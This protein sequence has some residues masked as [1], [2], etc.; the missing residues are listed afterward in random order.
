MTQPGGSQ[1]LRVATLCGSI[2]PL[3]SGTDDYD[4]ILTA[5]L[6]ERGVA[7]C[8]VNPGD[9]GL[10]AVRRLLQAVQLARPD[11]ILMQ[12]PTDAFGRSFAPHVFALLQ[13]I[14]PLVVTLHE[15]TASHVLRR[16]SIGP[17]LARAAGVVVTAEREMDGLRAWYPWLRRRLRL[18]PIGANV[19]ARTWRPTPTPNV[20]C[21]GQIRPGKGI[22][23]FIA[24]RQRLAVLAPQAE[25]T[26]IGSP[27]PQFAAYFT[28]IAEAAKAHDI[29]LITGL[30]RSGVSDRLSAASLALLPYP[31]G[32][33]F[34]RGSL[35]AAAVCGVPI[36][37]T[38][39]PDTPPALAAL[40]S[41]A[42]T[43]E[44]MTAL[45][46]GYLGDPALLERAHQNSRQIGHMTGWPAIADRYI[47]IFRSLPQRNVRPAM[48][49]G[50]A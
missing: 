19:P 48:A 29:G 24:C 15:F 32:A 25:F 10:P 30:D 3:F 44:D 39:G 38:T 22:E 1:A 5:A 34:R 40:L 20:V 31:G 18:I 4:E 11:A 9:W 49:V 26:L 47:D 21:F 45:A 42:T 13:R 37:S 46:A 6:R 16:A 41:P 2:K 35:L 23:E 12:Y 33:S 43:V 14:A 27:V 50:A 7:V 17:L 8:P 36:V 28:E